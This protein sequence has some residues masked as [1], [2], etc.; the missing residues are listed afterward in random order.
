MIKI[1]TAAVILLASSI[2]AI[3][4]PFC[5]AIPNG[6]PLC[7][8]YDGSACAR[9]AARQNGGCVVNPAE[10]HMPTTRVGDYCLVMPSGYTTCGYS[11]GNV[12]SRDAL[13]Q[14]GA[15]ERGTGAGP[16]QLPDAYEPNAGR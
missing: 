7:M 11:D 3:A 12:C 10:V 13:L 16:K 6:A 2:G 9:D 1:I 14:K 5:L 15:C 8:Y 4:A